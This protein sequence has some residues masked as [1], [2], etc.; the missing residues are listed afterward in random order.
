MPSGLHWSSLNIL[1]EFSHFGVP[2]K[3]W[4]HREL[5]RRKENCNKS[6][7]L[8][9]NVKM[10][11]EKGQ[12]WEPRWEDG[13]FAWNLQKNEKQ[14]KHTNHEW[15]K[16]LFKQESKKMGTKKMQDKKNYG[17]R[18]KIKYCKFCQN[19]KEFIL[20]FGRNHISISIPR[21][22]TPNGVAGH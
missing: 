7:R 3:H 18:K 6:G 17:L 14:M 2:Q 11:N 16:F 15:T 22:E 1:N 5:T 20:T 19:W 21:K 9:G 8:E 12:R 10:R 13:I 4:S